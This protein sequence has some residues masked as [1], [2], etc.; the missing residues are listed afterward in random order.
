MNDNKNKSFELTDEDL[1]QVSGGHTNCTGNPD[2]PSPTPDL[3][4]FE[5]PTLQECEGDCYGTEAAVCPAL[6]CLYN[7]K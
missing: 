5:Q 4:P 7:R 1:E 6:I 2:I 3:P